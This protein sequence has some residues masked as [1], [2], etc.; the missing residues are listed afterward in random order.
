[1]SMATYGVYMAFSTET[2]LNAIEVNGQWRLGKPYKIRR[3]A[4]HAIEIT[5]DTIFSNI[6]WR[7]KTNANCKR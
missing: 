7:Y 2:P 5:E 4:I 6:L 3:H 1:M